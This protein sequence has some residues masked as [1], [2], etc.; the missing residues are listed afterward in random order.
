MEPSAVVA[1]PEPYDYGLIKLT[2]RALKGAHTVTAAVIHDRN[3]PQL[4]A[5]VGALRRLSKLCL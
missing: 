2:Q 4:A 3:E 1:L 5:A